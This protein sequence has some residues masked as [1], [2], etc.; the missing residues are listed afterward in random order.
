[1]NGFKQLIG[2]GILLA[3]VGMAFAGDSDSPATRPATTEPAAT[4]PSGVLEPVKE[5]TT[6]PADPTA[7]RH[8]RVGDGD[9]V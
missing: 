7:G 6:Q 4:Q 8:A 5:G 1:M 3:I 9:R 2:V